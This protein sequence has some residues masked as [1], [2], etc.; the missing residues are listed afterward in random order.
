M[1]TLTLRHTRAEALQDLLDGLSGAWAAT[2]VPAAAGNAARTSAS[3]APIRT[4]RK[5]TPFLG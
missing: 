3:A 4:F 2:V 1:L 5:T